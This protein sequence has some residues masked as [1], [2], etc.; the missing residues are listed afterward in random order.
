MSE[1]V[2]SSRYA[3]ALMGIAESK[4]SFQIIVSD[5]NLICETLLASK[6][7]RNLL[8]NPVV[9]ENKKLVI[10]KEV[11][12]SHI[13][14]EVKKFL[15]F[16]VEKGRENLL[17]DIGKRFLTLSDDKMNQTKVNI[18][19][20]IELTANQK[21]KLNNKL[22]ALLNK[23]V[24]SDFSINSSLIGGFKAKFNDTVIDASVQHQLELLKKKLFGQDF[25]SN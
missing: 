25:L 24:I 4:D 17:Y 8:S 3:N 23:K 15:I 10:L 12:D 6:E 2:I 14:D 20:A 13:S 21:E 7:L 9:P 5:I 11:F 1:F 22:E 18:T 19:S 16:L